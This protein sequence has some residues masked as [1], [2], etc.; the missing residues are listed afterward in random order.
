MKRMIA[1][2]VP[3]MGDAS[4]PGFVI[5]PNVADLFVDTKSKSDRISKVEN[6]QHVLMEKLLTYLKERQP[7]AL[8][9]QPYLDLPER[10]AQRHYR[11]A[12]PGIGMFVVPGT[13]SFKRPHMDSLQH[14]L[15][16]LC[17][18]PRQNVRG[19]TP[20]LF[21]LHR[22][23][24]EA[25]EIADKFPG[26]RLY[27]EKELVVFPRKGHYASVRRT[28]MKLDML[29]YEKMP[30]LIASNRIEDGIMH[31]ATPIRKLDKEKRWSRPI[32]YVAIKC[33]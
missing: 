1:M 30:M 14:V 2:L 4:K 5:L 28:Q 29:D 27:H 32:S 8:A 25:G 7:G 20:L 15:I 21:D 3:R 9:P 19:G 24:T 31:G 12:K 22:A 11:N 17:Y 23:G 33:M 16:S 13:T 10:E 26:I 6:F 18:Y